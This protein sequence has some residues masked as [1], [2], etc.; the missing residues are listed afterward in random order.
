[1]PT[2]ITNRHM[3]TLI[4]SLLH[5]RLIMGFKRLVGWRQ[6]VLGWPAAMYTI[7]RWSDIGRQTESAYYII[8]TYILY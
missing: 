7:H 4:K 8:D 3:D 6:L 5:Y 2:A 1:M